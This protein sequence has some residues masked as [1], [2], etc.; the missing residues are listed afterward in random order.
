MSVWDFFSRRQRRLRGEFPDVYQYERIPKELRAQFVHILQDVAGQDVSSYSDRVEAAYHTIR[1]TLCREYGKFSLTERPDP[2]EDVL[3]FILE[4]TD[5]ERILD[6]VEVALSVFEDAHRNY[7]YISMA[8]PQL[9]TSDAAHE[10]NQRL[11]EHGV[12]FQL[13]GLQFIR[14]DS[15]VLHTE[16]VKPLLHLLADRRFRGPNAEFLSAHAHYRDGRPKEALNDC[17]KAFE[18]TMKTICDLKNWTYS[19]NATAKTL[20]QTCFDHGLV[21]PYLQSEFSALRALLESG[22]PTVRNRESGHG[23]GA[24]PR[25]VPTELVEYVLHLSASTMLFLVRSARFPAA[26]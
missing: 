21:P 6:A 2:A 20:I 24:S 1:R 5:S 18:S 11:R 12:G 25:E 16:A 13:E 7:E 23:Q 15:E 3:R 10:V 14:V 19:P 22:V 17:L 26:G 9:S 4:E 8:N